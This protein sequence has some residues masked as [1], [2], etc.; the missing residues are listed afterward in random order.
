MIYEVDKTPKR[1]DGAN[2]ATP[3]A[4]DRSGVIGGAISD[5]EVREQGAGER[6]RRETQ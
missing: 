3:W 1:R 5:L 6:P 2:Q 4:I